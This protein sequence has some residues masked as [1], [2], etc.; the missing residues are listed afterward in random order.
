MEK[1]LNCSHK[2]E[3]TLSGERKPSARFCEGIDFMSL[4]FISMELRKKLFENGLNEEDCKGKEEELHEIL[5]ANDFYIRMMKDNL[6]EE[7][8]DS[9][10][11]HERLKNC[12]NFRA[13]VIKAFMTNDNPMIGIGR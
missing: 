9:E 12:E 5:K 8:Y 6:L 10:K 11:S 2:D 3:C 7:L 13:K 4:I 1:N